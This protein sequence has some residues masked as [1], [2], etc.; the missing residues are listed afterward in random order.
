MGVDLLIFSNHSIKGKSYQERIKNIELRLGAKI[1]SIPNVPYENEYVQNTTQEIEDT[2]YYCDSID[3]KEHFRNFN[4]IKIKT[5]YEWF[6]GIRMFDKTMMLIPNNL[7]TDN[8]KWKLYLGDGF[9]RKQKSKEY[10]DY[11]KSWKK[12][13]KFQLYILK[14]LGGTQTI[15]F[16]DHSFQEPEDLFY[17]GKSIDET[18]PELEKIGPFLEIKQLYYNFDEISDKFRCYGFKEQT[19]LRNDSA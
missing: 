15:Y 6:S 13:Q 12:F 17:Q 2:I 1:N 9:E 16:D 14:I 11:N 5:N 19:K 7:S 4:E 18:L 8:Y 3:G 10:V